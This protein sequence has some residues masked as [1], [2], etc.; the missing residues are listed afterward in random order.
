MNE[1]LPADSSDWDEHRLAQRDSWTSTF[2]Q[3]PKF[4]GIFW[5]GQEP[6]LDAHYPWMPGNACPKTPKNPQLTNSELKNPS[7]EGAL[8]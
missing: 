7:D 3:T 1:P 8:E 6:P 5:A 2:T 4:V